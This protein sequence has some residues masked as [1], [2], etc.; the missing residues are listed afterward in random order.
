MSDEPPIVTVIIAAR[1]DQAE[2]KAVAAARDLDYPPD[3]LEIIVAR[4]KQPSVQRNTAVRKAR[5]EFIY[6][7]DDDSIADSQNLK[8][9]I[10]R[11]ADD[12]VQMVGG[13][14]LCPL[15]APQIEKEFATVMANSLAFGPSRARYAPI[16]T[17]RESS[18]K[19]LIL[20]NLIARRSAFLEAGGFDEALYPNEENA[21]MDELSKRGGKLLY[22]PEF[23]AERRPR[24][25]MPSFSKMLKNYGRGRAEQFRLH[26]TSGSI[27]NLAPPALV[28]YS[29]MAPFIFL[30]SSLVHRAIDRT[31]LFLLVNSPLPI[32][33]LITFFSAIQTRRFPTS[34]GATDD[35]G[36]YMGALRM[37]R[38]IMYCHYGYGE[39]FLRG[40][41]TSLKPAEERPEIEV[42]LEVAQAV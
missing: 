31:D 37:Q 35:G 12:D 23:V 16:G 10:E 36:F 38:L 2:V 39:G 40:L 30:I 42:K 17:L 26:P 4:G 27:L 33:F 3:R 15:D 7:L 14:N 21:L 9:A 29:I 6:F 24:P 41:R 34:P 32:Y 11:F 5:G 13:P 18:E 28:V 20:C 19:E 25:D 8:R 1:P 22:D